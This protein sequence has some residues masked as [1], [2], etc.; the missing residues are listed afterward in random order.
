MKIPLT[1]LIVQGN[2][3]PNGSVLE[4]VDVVPVEWAGCETGTPEMIGKTYIADKI[5]VHSWHTKVRLREFPDRV[6]N[7]VSFVFDDGK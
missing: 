1:D 5:E 6:F 3:P 2:V 4:F 7:S